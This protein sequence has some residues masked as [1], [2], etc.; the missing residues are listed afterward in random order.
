MSPAARRLLLVAAP[1]LA[2]A[3]L[4]LLIMALAVAR[5][6]FLPP[7]PNTRFAGFDGLQVH[8]GCLDGTNGRHGRVLECKWDVHLDSRFEILNHDHAAMA[9]CATWVR[10]GNVRD[11]WTAHLGDATLGLFPPVWGGWGGCNHL[12]PLSVG[13]YFDVAVYH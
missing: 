8:G 11:L 1:A 13:F 3:G 2:L 9:W 6:V 5:A 10:D 7:V 12:I 4:P